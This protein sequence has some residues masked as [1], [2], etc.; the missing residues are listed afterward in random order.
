MQQEL[1]MPDSEAAKAWRVAAER[2][3]EDPFRGPREREERRAYYLRR[4]EEIERGERS[5]A[6]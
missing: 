6:R 1:A 5:P 2:A 3:L 4:A